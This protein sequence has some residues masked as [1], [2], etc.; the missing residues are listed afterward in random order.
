VLGT[1]TG[2]VCDIEKSK[3]GG[4]VVDEVAA[5]LLLRVANANVLELIVAGNEEVL[6]LL[7]LLVLTLLVLLLAIGAAELLAVDDVSRGRRRRR[8][9]ASKLAVVEGTRTGCERCGAS[10]GGGMRKSMVPSRMLSTV[11]STEPVRARSRAIARLSRYG[12][13][14]CT[15]CTS[16]GST[17]RTPESVDENQFISPDPAAGSGAPCA[18]ALSPPS[19]ST[20][21]S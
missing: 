13:M 4:V 2:G 6:V 16:L 18:P 21:S 8:A 19:S 11:T 12:N 5:A 14:S 3:I 20:T 7:V 15:C 10:P 9:V 17:R 1:R